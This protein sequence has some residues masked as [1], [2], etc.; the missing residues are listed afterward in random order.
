MKISQ[1]Q[2]FRENFWNEEKLTTERQKEDRCNKF[3]DGSEKVQ[4]LDTKIRQ[5][6]LGKKSN[7]ASEES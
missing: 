2:L 7:G 6:E 1:P 3:K 5:Q 4:I